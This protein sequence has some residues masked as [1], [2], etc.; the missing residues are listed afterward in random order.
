[1]VFLSGEK[2][3]PKVRVYREKF[4]TKNFP[5]TFSSRFHICWDYVIQFSQHFPMKIFSPSPFFGLF[6][7]NWEI[8]GKNVVQFC[9]FWLS[10]IFFVFFFLFCMIWSYI[11]IFRP[12][13]HRKHHLN[14]KWGDLI[15]EPFMFA[16]RDIPTYW[17]GTLFS[18]G[19]IP[20]IL[21]E[22]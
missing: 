18:I 6:F 13:E 4:N 8:W 5:Q 7:L 14:P 3:N 22:I 1:M 20:A 21:V 9:V 12:P 11:I 17:I 19:N 2:S 10:Y 15:S 16:F